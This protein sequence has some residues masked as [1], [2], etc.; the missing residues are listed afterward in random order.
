M[1][2]FFKGLFLLLAIISFI[3]GIILGCYVTFY[4]MIY[5]SIIDIVIGITMVPVNA[6]LIAQGIVKILLCAIPGLATVILGSLLG[7]GFL[8]VWSVI[9]DYELK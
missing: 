1:K 6:I 7:L 5:C 9:E 3:V 2:N 4:Q 8:A